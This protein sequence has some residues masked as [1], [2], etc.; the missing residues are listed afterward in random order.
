MFERRYFC[1]TV[2]VVFEMMA[3]HCNSD[4][5]MMLFVFESNAELKNSAVFDG[6]VIIILNDRN[7]YSTS[8]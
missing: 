7:Y 1:G 6:H 2:S 8:I 4:G 5:K 3:F